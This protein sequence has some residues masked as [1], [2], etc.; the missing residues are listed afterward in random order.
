L[1]DWHYLKEIQPQ[2]DQRLRA[3]GTDPY[4]LQIHREKTEIL[5][6]REMTERTRSVLRQV[7][8]K[9]MYL[10]GFTQP[11]LITQI[12][13]SI[14]LPWDRTFEIKIEPRISLVQLE[15]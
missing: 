6:R 15:P 9:P 5:I 14:H 12:D 4:N 10:P 7:F 2:I 11:F 1:D 8:N 13:N 3:S